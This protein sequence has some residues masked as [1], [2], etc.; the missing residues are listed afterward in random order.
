MWRFAIDRQ[1]DDFPLEKGLDA[2]SKTIE[3]TWHKAERLRISNVEFCTQDGYSLSSDA[4]SFDG[5]LVFNVLHFI[6]E[7]NR[8]LKE[9]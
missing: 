8:I 3:V 6:K 4:R 2:P 7:P 9:T 5:V 1:S